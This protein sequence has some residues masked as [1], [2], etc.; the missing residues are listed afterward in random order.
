MLRRLF[1]HGFGLVLLTACAVRMPEVPMSAFVG[2]DIDTVRAT[3]EDELQNGEPENL[4]LVH[5]ILG[6]CLLLQGDQDGAWRHF[7]IAGRMM[8]NWSVSGSE[9]FAAIVGSEGSK[10]YKGDPYEKGMNAFYLALCYLWRGEPDN[11]RAALKRG[12]LADA[13]VGDERYQADNAMLFWLAGRMS[14]LMGLDADADGYFAEARTAIEFAVAHG[15][16]GAA[17]MPTWHEPERGNLVLLLECG[18]G[19][20]KF[21]AG[22]M[23]ELARFR[24]GHHLAKTAR[25]L[26]DGEPHGPNTV[27]CDVG[28]QARTL[29]GTEMEGIREG[30]AVFKTSALIAGDILLRGAAIG[31]VRNKNKDKVRTAAIVGGGLILLGLL[32]Q[33]E[34]DIRHWPTLPATVEVL[35]LDVEPGPHELAIEFLDAQ[36]RVLPTLRQQWSLDIPANSES[37]YLFRSLPGLD[38]HIQ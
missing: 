37:Y 17:D 21:A 5:N 31:H 35:C 3:L 23:G 20:E 25:V 28:Y 36:G 24:P 30:K 26:L 14:R 32:T 8:G 33:A 6:Q 4:A 13:E 2:G 9:E 19:P 29:G 34:A 18:L 7:D 38:G 27:L 15:S 22:R 10:N 12:I 16:E 11:A 1:A